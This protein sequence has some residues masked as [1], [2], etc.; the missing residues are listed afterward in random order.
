VRNRWSSVA[1]IPGGRGGAGAAVP[2]GKLYVIGGTNLGGDETDNV[3]AY[4]PGTNK[5]ITKAS[6]PSARS[7][8]EAAKVTVG[9]QP[10]IVAVGG[11]RFVTNTDET[12][13]YTP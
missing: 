6:L 5:W 11:F 3:L 4:D 9:G 2:G 8:L 10:R 1:P 7:S 13:L 12:D